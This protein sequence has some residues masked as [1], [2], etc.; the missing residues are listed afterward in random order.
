MASVGALG[1]AR[2]VGAPWG[3][4]CFL[5]LLGQLMRITSSS[6]TAVSTAVSY[7]QQ[8]LGREH[9]GTPKLHNPW[10]LMEGQPKATPPHGPILALGGLCL[11][12][13]ASSLPTQRSYLSRAVGGVG[14]CRMEGWGWLLVLGAAVL[15]GEC[16]LLRGGGGNSCALFMRR[17]PP[18]GAELCP[19]LMPREEWGP[20]PYGPPASESSV[21]D[22]QSGSPPLNPLPL[23]PL[24]LGF[25]ADTEPGTSSA[26]S[27]A[28]GEVGKQHFKGL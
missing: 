14:G 8:S 20:L 21:L 4:L 17:C 24:F 9:R 5:A 16:P 18:R 25:Y 13:A 26:A 19:V 7:R 12:A 28:L 3:G 1:G 23:C 22:G 2:R 10:V 6:C 27:P 15:L 11:L